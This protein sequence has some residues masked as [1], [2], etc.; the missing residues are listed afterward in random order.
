M[1]NNACVGNIDYY[2][3]V[4]HRVSASSVE[5]YSTLS[6][7]SS[8]LTQN[9]TAG[10]IL[11]RRAELPNTDSMRSL[12]T[13]DIVTLALQNHSSF[14]GAKAA[15]VDSISWTFRHVAMRYVVVIFLL[16]SISQLP[17]G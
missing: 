4:G 6:A 3:I 10:I 7:T 11:L 13:I 17:S 8:L 9:G 16:I 5:S 14:F 2:T 12:V 15:D 1:R